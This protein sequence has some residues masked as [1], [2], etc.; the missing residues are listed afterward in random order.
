MDTI[1]I[2]SILITLCAVF[3]YLNLRFLGLPTAIGIMVMALLFSV[4]VLLLPYAGLDVVAPIKEFMHD[5]DFSKT[6]M[7]GMLSILLFAGALHVRLDNLREQKV[8]IAVMAG[9]G[10]VFSAVATGLLAYWLFPHFGLEVPLLY[11][12]LFGTLIAPTDPVAVM[13]ILKKVGVS[14]SLETKIVGESLFNDGVAVVMFVVL[15][16]L[17]KGTEPTV[18]GVGM[19]LLQEIAGGAVLGLV[20]G[21]VV[22]RMLAS[23]D[24][25]PVEILLTLALVIGG[26]DLALQL[27]VSGPIVVVVAGLLIGNHARKNAMSERNREYLD[28]F[29]ELCDEFLNAVLFLLIGLEIFILTTDIDAYTAGLVMIPLVLLVRFLS[30]FLPMTVLQRRR[31]FSDGAV[32]ILTWGALRGGVSVALALSLPASPERDF[33]LIVTYCIVLFSILGQGLTIGKVVE[34]L[35]RGEK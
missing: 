23:I 27:H 10:T 3:G 32:G 18:S 6:L 17:L 8:M 22:Y 1:S 12:L 9:F 5:I 29:W 35:S 33:I 16:Q 15:L 11:A 20:L 2:A 13:A 19:L 25:Y 28:A 26:Y 21:Y 7:H 30:V 31:P 34:K 14:K 4:V 24:N